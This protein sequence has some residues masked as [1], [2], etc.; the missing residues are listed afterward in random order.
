[1]LAFGWQAS[2]MQ[3]KSGGRKPPV[4]SLP[5][6]HR[7]VRPCPRTDVARRTKSRGR[8]PPVVNETC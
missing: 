6:L 1:M 2:A 5:R 8:K 7:R 3:H 4:V